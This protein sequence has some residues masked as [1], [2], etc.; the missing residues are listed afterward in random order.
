MTYQIPK[1]TEIL[2]TDI[3][4]NAWNGFLR[5]KVTDPTQLAKLE[6]FDIKYLGQSHATRLEKQFSD[7]IWEQGG[8]IIRKNGQPMLQ[9]VDAERATLFALRWYFDNTRI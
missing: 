2:G 9:F 3:L 7:W 8:M 6:F 5:K 4:Q 1:D